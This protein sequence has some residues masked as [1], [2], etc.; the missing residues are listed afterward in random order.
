MN[1]LSGYGLL[2]R[3]LP[4]FDPTKRTHETPRFL[5]ADHDAVEAALERL[6]PAGRY[7]RR[8]PSI[9]RCATACSPAASGSG[10]FC[11]WKRRECFQRT[12]EGAVQVGCA[13][14]FIHTYSLIHDD[15]PALDN[16][17]LRRGKPT[18]HK[19]F[20]EAIAILAGDALLTLAFQ[21]LAAAPVEPQR[22]L[23]ILDAVARGGWNRP[24]HG[25]RASGRHRSRTQASGWRG[26][27]IHSS[28]E[29]GGADSRVGGGR[30]DRGRRGA[31][32]YHALD[33]ASAKTSAGRFRWWT[34]F[35]T[36]RNRPLRSA[37]PR[38]KIRRSRR[39]PIRR[40]TASRNR[41]RLRPTWKRRRSAELDAYGERAA[42]LRQVANFWWRAGRDLAMKMSERPP[43][44]AS[45]QRQTKP[46]KERLDLL[47]V[48]RS[49]RLRGSARRL[50]CSPGKFA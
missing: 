45:H 28:L 4:S 16:D 33:A 7:C 14:E 10:R 36:W 18:N 24:R 30:R 13:L 48:A 49:W 22:R 32:G 11:A 5:Q 15:L 27:R 25:R 47:L 41:A 40:S 37:R 9:A 12:S 31:A 1:R 39:L 6:L 8:R 43:S 3:S 38:A 42:R 19:V 50:W 44:K 34:I 17:D 35:S 23:K 2:P 46:G 20:G 26:A 29:D 21:T